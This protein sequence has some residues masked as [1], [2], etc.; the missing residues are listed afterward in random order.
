MPVTDAMLAVVAKRNGI[1]VLT[2]DGHF[3][4]LG[5]EVIDTLESF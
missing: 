2:A 1:A 5:V 4:H 3:R